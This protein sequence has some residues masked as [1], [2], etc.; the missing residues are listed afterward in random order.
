M[1]IAGFLTPFIIGGV[2]F[3]IAIALAKGLHKE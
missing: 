3:C 1:Y 2:L